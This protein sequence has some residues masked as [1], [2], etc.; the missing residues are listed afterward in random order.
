MNN[1]LNY[2]TIAE[3]AFIKE[4][5]TESFPTGIVSLVGDSFDLWSVITEILP[6]LK[7]KIMARDGK[8]VIRPDSGNP[9]DII[10]GKPIKHFTESERSD[11]EQ[12]CGGW[13][14][15]LLED[16][17][18]HGE[19]G[20]SIT[21]T[22]SWNGMLFD[23][24]YDP[25]WS[26]YDKQF[27][28]IETNVLRAWKE[29]TFAERTATPQD[30]GVIELLWNTFGGTV[31]EQGYKVLDSHIGAI[32]GDS[33]TLERQVE[34]YKRLAEKG[35]AATN[36]ILGIGSFTYQYNTRDTF[37]WAAKGSWFEIE[38]HDVVNERLGVNPKWR[39][40]FS[41]YKDPVTDDGTKKSLKGM[42]AVMDSLTE[43]GKMYVKEECTEE[44]ERQGHLKV[45]YVDGFF[46]NQISLNDV[47]S[48][49]MQES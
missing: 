41:I 44:E 38:H 43:V 12:E 9:V 18:P 40:S 11:F 6:R 16:E 24:K 28:Y 25:D 2:R 4:M 1:T 35:F 45:I 23:V 49:I 14:H 36:I 29:C 21:R 17:T 32:Y 15:Q 7:D 19:H 8:L 33:I 3:Y 31:N 46:H 26:R 48:R 47:R 39:E 34:I 42:V 27:Y 20:G 10:C 30:I 5:I 13:L 37:G 22:V